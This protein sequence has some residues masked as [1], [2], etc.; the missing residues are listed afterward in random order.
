MK[1]IGLFTMA[2]MISVLLLGCGMNKNKTETDK[3]STDTTTNTVPPENSTPSEVEDKVTGGVGDNE[4]KLEVAK[5]AANLITE[6]DEVES[7]TVIVTN[8]NAYTAVVLH[9]QAS[10][11]LSPDVEDKI[12]DKVRTANSAIENVYVSL[13]PDFVKQ[14]NDYGEKINEGKPVEGFF[15]EFSEAMKRVFPDAH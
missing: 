15:E 5:D 8:N 3:T 7:A 6:L 4:S 11:E 12:A 10:E 14:M 13:N 1:R 2:L 9:D